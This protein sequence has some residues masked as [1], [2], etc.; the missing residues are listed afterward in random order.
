MTGDPRTDV[1]SRQYGRWVYPDPIEDLPGWLA[2]NWQWFDPSHAHRSLWPDRDYPADLR[3]LVAG[4][5]TNQAAVL[6]YTNPSA[7]VV[8]ID[9]SDASL[10]HHRH[11]KDKYGLDNLDLHLLPIEES[12]ALP[13]EFDLIVSTGVL[14]HLADPQVGMDVLAGKL[15]RDGV[16]A[17][18]LYARYGRLGVEMMQSVF[19]DL[20]LQQDEESLLVVRQALAALPAEHPVRSYLSI[21]PDLGF[22]AGLVDTFLH[23]RD[24]SY[25]VDECL[26]LVSSAGLAFQGWFLKS[27]YEPVAG[28]GDAFLDA[29]AAL[30]DERRWSV[31]E[32]VHSRNAVHFF[33]AC[34]ADRPTD[35][36]RVTFE[37][38]RRGHYVPMF[39]QRCRLD[40]DAVVRPGWRGP[41]DHEQAAIMALVNGQRT[42][43]DIAARARQ[44]AA[45]AHLSAAEVEA[46]VGSL[47]EYLW[48]RDVLA[49]ALP[50]VART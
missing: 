37:P 42:I 10:Q 27:P 17:V 47:M 35:D 48:K 34:R 43:G 41:L 49:I 38:E 7:S 33:T 36:Y 13:G 8:A 26:E 19:R 45:L 39:R 25:T 40:G 18:M 1:V 9:V 22:D 23:G 29:V 11:L 44:G 4:C 30:P 31:M 16:L 6:A 32:R 5:G 2:T 12:G 50:S 46:A 3:I 15:S 20:G 24:R 14:H 28:S 21:A